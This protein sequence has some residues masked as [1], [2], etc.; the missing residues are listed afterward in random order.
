MTDRKVC[1]ITGSS[2]GIGAAKTT[3]QLQLVDGG[4]FIGRL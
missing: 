4:R 2:S 1:V 3:G